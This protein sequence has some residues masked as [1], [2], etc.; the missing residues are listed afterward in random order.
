MEDVEEARY[1]VEEV[2][3]NNVDVEETGENMDPEMHQDDTECEMEGIEEDD[4]YIHLDPEGLK[5][6]DVPD[7]RNWYKKLE[8]IDQTE[9]EEKTC[10]LDK[11]QRNVIDVALKFVRGLRK[12]ENGVDRLPRA[13]NLVVIGGAGSGKSTVI[14]CLTQ[15]CHRL[16]EKSG[17]DP[18]SP[19]ILKAATTG[20][21]SSLIEGSTVHSSLGFDFSSKHTSLSDKT[22]EMRIEQMKNLRILVIDEFSMMKSDI[23][24]RIHLRLSELKHNNNYFGG[25][26]VI[27]F[28]DP[29]QLKPVRGSYIFAAPNCK[30][31]TLAYGDGTDSLWRSFSVINLE[32]NHRQGKDKSYADMLN[33]IRVGKHTQEDMEI[34]KSRVRTKGHADTKGALFISAKVIPVAK[35]NDISLIKTAGK[36]YVSQATH[37][38]AMAKTYKPKID[39]KSGRIGDTQFVDEFK[40]KIGARVILIF[41]IDV[42]DLLCNGALGSVLGVEE[43]Q[44][45]KITAVIVK[46][47]NPVAG[48]QA[49]ERNPGLAK[50]YPQG[51]IVK[52]MEQE[53]S[54]ARTQG[55]ISSTARL[56]QF[57]LVLAWAVTV[58][59][60]QGQT[61]KAPQKVVVDLKSVFEAAQAYVMASRVQELEQLYILEELP[62]DKI[63]ANQAALAEIERL[64]QVSKNKNPTKWLNQDQKSTVRISFLNCRSIK[65]K[66]HNILSDR[67]LLLS[68]VMILTE[69]WLKEN[70]DVSSYTLPGYDQNLNKRGR[71]KGISTYYKGMDLKF[72]VDINHDGFS[73]SKMS[74]RDLDII[75]VY[76]S[77]NGSI[78]NMINEII[79][80]YNTDKTTVIGGDFN[81]CFIKQPKN[82]VTTS[83]ADIG[84]KQI[85]T[86]ATHIEG[87]T[88]DHIYIAQGFCK[89]NYFELELYPKYYSDHDGLFLTIWKTS[90]GQ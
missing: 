47:D 37:I 27:L 32:E 64:V 58:H 83:L 82:S 26:L 56:I 69:T 88:I 54:L 65:N 12:Y 67:S 40:F 11:W 2:M 68:D 43:G 72:E 51:T 36:L 15:W 4:K 81:I 55:L 86:E 7:T 14:E 80:L 20:A 85:V 71:G 35:F 50:K 90:E 61:V 45:G 46:F 21:A 66:F 19:Y 22:R 13:E 57:P 8:L 3:K 70:D 23:L 6:R 16:L 44:N 52:K 75:G 5:D 49:R 87:G 18:N 1:F 33:R 30:D 34:L 53:Y 28:G 76:R 10:K 9:L 79:K 38:Q 29:A 62:K 78:V 17:D 59:K 25:V 48:K 31:Y 42:S 24:Y 60:F 41:N 84:F 73:L 77:Q 74:G 89:K 63:Y 39:K